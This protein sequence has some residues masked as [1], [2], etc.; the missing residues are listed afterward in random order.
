MNTPLDRCYDMLADVPGKNLEEKL[1]RYIGSYMALQIEASQLRSQV[2]RM[3]AALTASD[4][5][6]RE[7]AN[8]HNMETAEGRRISLALG[9]IIAENAALLGP[10]P[11]LT[12]T[13]RQGE[14]E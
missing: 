8:Q 5:V 6:I 2:E 11:A 4:D 3:R 1:T 14:A 12:S 7:V 9:K 10:V 13:A